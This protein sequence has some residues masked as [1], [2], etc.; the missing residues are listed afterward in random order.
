MESKNIDEEKSF[1]FNNNRSSIKEKYI[2]TNFYK[3]QILILSLLFLTIINLAILIRSNFIINKIGGN[4]IKQVFIEKKAKQIQN[5]ITNYVSKDLM[6]DYLSYEINRIYL[7]EINEKRTFEKRFPLPKEI[8]CRSHMTK[9][10]FFIISN[11]Q[12]YFF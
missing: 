9:N 4:Q 10:E 8:D 1:N 6:P 2:Y 5:E 7:K 12:Y 11:K 3:L